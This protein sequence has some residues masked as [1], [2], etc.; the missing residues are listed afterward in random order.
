M[1]SHV[2][3]DF[4]VMVADKSVFVLVMLNV[5]PILVKY[6]YFLSFFVVFMTKSFFLLIFPSSSF[7][8]FQCNCPAG[9]V[10]LQCDRPCDKGK[11]GEKCEFDCKCQNGA[12]CN[13]VNG[14]FLFLLLLLWFSSFLSRLLDYGEVLDEISCVCLCFS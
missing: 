14:Q 10:G 1:K 9:F 8:F 3:R 4:L 13:A 5:I 12:S 7:S 2:Y 11:F 6:V